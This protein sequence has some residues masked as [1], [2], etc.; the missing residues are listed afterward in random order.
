MLSER[1]D[2]SIIISGESGAGKSEAT[3]LMLQ[4]VA[5]GHRDPLYLGTL[6]SRIAHYAWPSLRA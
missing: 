4:Y 5:C 2:Q 3:K 1:T 6:G